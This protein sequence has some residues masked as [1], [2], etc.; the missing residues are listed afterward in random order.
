MPDFDVEDK[1]NLPKET[2]PFEI[3]INSEE[4]NGFLSMIKNIGIKNILNED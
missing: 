2:F 3:N 1:N 4:K